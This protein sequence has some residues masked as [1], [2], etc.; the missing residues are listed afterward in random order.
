MSVVAFTLYAYDKVQALKNERRVSE[1]KLLF[2]AL[3]SGTIGSILSMLLFRHKI[4]KPSF[5]IK[6]SIIVVLQILVI[7]FYITKGI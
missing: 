3:I 2:F 4:K 7:Y 6:F 5:M 1:N